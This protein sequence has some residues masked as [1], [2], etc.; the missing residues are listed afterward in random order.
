MIN[1][2]D[3]AKVYLTALKMLALMEFMD[4]AMNWILEAL[5]L[6]APV[7]TS[8][9]GPQAE[10]T[11]EDISLWDDAGILVFFGVS[12]VIVILLMLAIFKCN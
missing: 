7:E 11:T 5:G 1:I 10:V 3:N 9:C 8:G 2:P 4:D 12:A 6:K